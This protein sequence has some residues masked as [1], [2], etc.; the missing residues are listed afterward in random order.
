VTDLTKA[1]IDELLRQGMTIERL[2]IAEREEGDDGLR[3]HGK[4]DIPALARAV[5][6][7]IREPT[8]AMVV[9]GD[10]AKE[11]CIDSDWESDADGNPRDYTIINSDL[12]AIVFRAMIDAALSEGNQ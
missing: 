9:A 8:K 1:I 2:P 5:I 4:L 3:I 6:G 10:D 7:A 11:T 12:P